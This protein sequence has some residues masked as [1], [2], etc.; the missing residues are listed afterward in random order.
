MKL[1]ALIDP[2]ILAEAAELLPEVFNAKQYKLT[3]KNDQTG[4]AKV[5]RWKVVEDELRLYYLK[6]DNE[7]KP[8]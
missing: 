6:G 8:F 4:V 1:D 2:K 3:A 7:G 5:F